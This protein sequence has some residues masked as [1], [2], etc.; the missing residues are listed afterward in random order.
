MERGLRMSFDIRSLTPVPYVS[1]FFALKLDI[2]SCGPQSEN[3]GTRHT[4]GESRKTARE[5]RHCIERDGERLWR[6]CDF[7]GIPPFAL[8]QALSRLARQGKLRRVSKGVYYHGRETAF[9]P[10][11]PN[12]AAIRKLASRDKR[13]FPAGVAAANLLGFTSQSAGRV[14]V[15]TS[16]FRLPRKLLGRDTVV[17]TR[18]PEAWAGLPEDEAALLDFMRRGGRTSELSPEETA[19]RLLHLFRHPRR[20]ERILK[21][22]PTEPP[23]VRAMLGAIGE[24]L[25]KPAHALR[26]LR[27]SLNAVSRFDFGLLEALPA[28][29]RWQ[30]KKER[31]S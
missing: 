7:P 19:R 30:A 5:V 3:V 6:F 1:S 15:A 21:V 9:G 14:E 12:P 4:T 28:A 13:I 31:R 16:G 25:G 2:L 23:R 29:D 26:G 17:H 8:A 27:E 20:F 18:R 10:S 24:V 11:L 22:A